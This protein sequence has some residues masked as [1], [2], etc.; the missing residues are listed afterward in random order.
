MH[1]TSTATNPKRKNYNRNTKKMKNILLTLV[2]LSTAI[3]AMAQGGQ[4]RTVEERVKAVHDSFA[5]NFQLD[6]E[7]LA[8]TDSIF[9]KFY[10]EQDKLRTEMR[11]S[12]ERPNF[13]AMREKMQPVAEA[14]DKEL[15]TILT[16][17][18]YKKWKD[19]LEPALSPRRGNG[20]GRS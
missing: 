9:T 4:R 11:S 13:E 10:N 5:S 7:K 14:R 20:G 18:Q 1:P 12:G 6:K 3:G 16:A 15:K 8:K 2:F 19:E 17:D